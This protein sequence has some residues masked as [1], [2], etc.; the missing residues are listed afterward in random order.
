[1]LDVTDHCNFKCKH[2]YKNQPEDYTDL[3]VEKVI[4]FLS[5]LDK[6]GY[7]PSIVIS[8][9][10]PLM[11]EGL[12]ELLDYIKPRKSVKLNTNGVLLKKYYKKFQDYPNLKIQVSLDGY[13][14]E[15]FFEI[16]NCHMFDSVVKNTKENMATLGKYVGAKS[17]GDL[18]K[19][20][21]EKM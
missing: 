17:Y 7:F 5:E 14:D 4:S 6:K 19:N 12:F 11:Y 16:R 15:T 2:C 18:F 10:E 8:G 3:N 1:M 9:G 20:Y 13:D 21:T